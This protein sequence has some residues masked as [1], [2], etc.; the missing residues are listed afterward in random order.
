MVAIDSV[1]L[2]FLRAEFADNMG[3]SGRARGAIDDYLHEAALANDPCSGTFYDPE[4]DGIQMS[5][6]GV[7]EHWNNSFDKQYSRNLDPNNAV[8]I[9]LISSEPLEPL[10]ED[11][12]ENY[13]V[14]MLDFNL[15]TATLPSS[16]RAARSN[17]NPACELNYKQ[18]FD[19]TDSTILMNFRHSMNFLRLNHRPRPAS[20]GDLFL[21]I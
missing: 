17:G 21:P 13:S 12:D 11:I 10:T 14:D 1:A 20:S 18:G 2:D 7:H 16:D 5:S 9:E 8:G 6:L 15:L 3:G 4:A 19:F